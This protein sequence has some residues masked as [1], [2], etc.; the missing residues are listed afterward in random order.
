MILPKHVD[1]VVRTMM[2]YGWPEPK[3]SNAHFHATGDGG[4]VSY[5]VEWIDK[6]VRCNF[7]TGYGWKSLTGPNISTQA[8]G[9]VPLDDMPAKLLQAAGA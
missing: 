7:I 5:F 8:L 6:D 1:I 2:E 9:Y 3:I 4:P